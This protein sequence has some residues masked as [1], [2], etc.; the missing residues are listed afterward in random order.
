M[1]RPDFFVTAEAG[2][3]AVRAEGFALN[4]VYAE[5]ETGKGSDAIDRRPQLAAALKEARR[6]RCSIAVAKLD[7]L[8]RYVRFISS[9]MVHRVP[10]LVADLGPDVDPFILHLFA[11]FAQKERALVSKRTTEALAA[12]KARGVTLGNP[13]IGEARQ[14]AV[15][16]IV[17]RADQRAANV[18]PIMRQIQ[19]SGATSLRQIAE[20]LNARGISCLIRPALQPVKWYGG[21]L[22]RLATI[23]RVSFSV[24]L[25]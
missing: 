7:R 19:R 23:V 10:F 2:I 9:L 4:R 1:G 6:Q 11:A 22:P 17:D 21:M 3:G 13:R 14:R 15:A 20:A 24:L 12:A 8:S 16:E 5:V 25:R 18:I